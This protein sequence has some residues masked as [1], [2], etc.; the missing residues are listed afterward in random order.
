MK[1]YIIEV[2]HYCDRGSYV[3]RFGR[4]DE[5]MNSKK[6]DNDHIRKLGYK[7]IEG[8]KKNW[9]YNNAL[10]QHDLKIV[11]KILEFDV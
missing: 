9:Y 5:R 10:D 8:A 3:T 6:M 2:T 1:R 4:S 7:T 11:A